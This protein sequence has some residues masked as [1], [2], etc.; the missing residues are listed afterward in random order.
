MHEHHLPAPPAQPYGTLDVDVAEAALV[1]FV[2][3]L[4]L[5]PPPPNLG[6]G[7][8]TVTPGGG[9]FTTITDAL[10]SIT[11]ASH[12]KEY[13]VFV[14]PGVYEERG[15]SRPEDLSPATRAGN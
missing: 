8:V 12:T 15:R 1:A 2:E 11:D 13:E 14:G 4:K 5:R 7:Q 3:R 6:A 10:T 9:S